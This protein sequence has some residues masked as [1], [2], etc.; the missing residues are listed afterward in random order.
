MMFSRVEAIQRISNTPFQL[1]VIGGGAT[2]SGCALDARVRGLD[3]VLLEG[4]DFASGASSAST[5]LIHGGLRYLQ[6]GLAEMDFGQFRLVKTA[7][8]E[9]RIMMTNAPHLS[10]TLRISVPCR[11]LGDLFYYRIGL[12]MYDWLS[13]DSRLSDSSFA[14][15][16]SS[17][18]KMRWL[19]AD[20]LH[21]TVSYSDGQFDDARY[22]LAL[23]Q[24][25]AQ[26]GAEVLN[27]AFV[28]GFET[29]RSGKVIAA[30]VLDRLTGRSFRVN[31]QVFVNATGAVSD[32]IRQLANPQAK[33]RLQPS[34]GV[35]ILLPLPGD[36]G[37]E[38]LLIPHTEDGRLIFAIPWMNRLLVGTTDTP[39]DPA[40]EMTVSRGEAEYL[41]RHLNQYIV[42]QF[43][44]EEVVSAT[45]GLRP[46]VRAGKLSPT[47]QI[48]RDYEIETQ[49]ESG[50][51]SIMGGKWTVYRAMAEETINTVET[52][53]MGRVTPCRTQNLRLCGT[54]DDR[55]GFLEQ[56][57]RAY[58]ISL[59]LADHLFRKYG[60]FASRVLEPSMRN[61]D[62]LSPIAEGALPVQAEVVYCI[63]QEMAVSVEDVLARRLGLQ[64][65]DWNLALEA[66]PVVAGILAQELEWNRPTER[67]ALDEYVSLI[68]KF[69]EKI[70]LFDGA[71]ER[72][73]I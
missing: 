11:N 12:K 9:R 30:N 3:T 56:L 37:V 36:F 62:L 64:F 66:A 21:S 19:R 25:A 60:S 39:C 49:S 69:Q 57:M 33:P 31:A 4:A 44:L 1:C 6:Q 45:A 41:L 17:L 63:R 15:R 73:A 43:T 24:S 52:Q 14:D 7:L 27:H 51:I 38:A 29:N 72:T 13:G 65:F 71:E 67:D 59:A 20:G 54:E 42:P 61:G 8:R 55:D 22:S 48:S 50:L 58:P 70:G 23:L 5:K 46:L 16:G 53:L 40:D 28:S 35:H 18:A 34:K 68:R 2:G 26:S 47:K 32:H 10:Q